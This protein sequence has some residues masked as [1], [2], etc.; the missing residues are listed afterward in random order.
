MRDAVLRALADLPD[1]PRPGGLVDADRAA[2]HRFVDRLRL[3]LRLGRLA[4]RALGPG[5]DWVESAR[6]GLRDRVFGLGAGAAAPDGATVAFR[7]A[8]MAALDPVLR[9]CLEGEGYA[10]EAERFFSELDVRLAAVPGFLRAL[11]GGNGRDWPYLAWVKVPPGAPAD[12][13]KR[14]LSRLFEAM[15][16]DVDLEAEEAVADLAR[17]DLEARWP[18]ASVWGIAPAEWFARQSWNRNAGVRIWWRLLAGELPRPGEDWALKAIADRAV[19][20]L[21]RPAPAGPSDPWGFARWAAEVVTAAERR[22]SEFLDAAGRK[23]PW[24]ATLSVGRNGAEP[25]VFEPLPAEADHRLVD[26]RLRLALVLALLDRYRRETAGSAEERDEHLIQLARVATLL[27][28]HP[29]NSRLETAALV[30]CH[31]ARRAVY[32]A[33]DEARRAGPPVDRHLALVRAMMRLHVAGRSGPPVEPP[34][35]RVVEEIRATSLPDDSVRFRLSDILEEMGG[36]W[37]AIGQAPAGDLARARADADRWLDALMPPDW[38]QAD[39]ILIN[40]TFLERLD[41]LTA[42]RLASLL[43]LEVALARLLAHHQKAAVLDPAGAA[44][45]LERIVRAYRLVDYTIW[46]SRPSF[47]PSVYFRE[48]PASPQGHWYPALVVLAWGGPDL[49][50]PALAL[51]DRL[52]PQDRALA[53]E[54]RRA[55]FQRNETAMVTLASILE[56]PDAAGLLSFRHFHETRTLNLRL[57]A[58]TRRPHELSAEALVR[59]A[60]D[61][62]GVNLMV[63]GAGAGLS[64]EAVWSRLFGARPG[65]ET[66]PE[67]LKR[68]GS[69]PLLLKLNNID[70]AVLLAARCVSERRLP[71]PLRMGADRFLVEGNRRLLQCAETPESVLTIAQEIADRAGRQRIERY[72]KFYDDALTRSGSDGQPVLSGGFREAVAAPFYRRNIQRQREF[73]TTAIDAWREATRG[74]AGARDGADQLRLGRALRHDLGPLAVALARGKEGHQPGQPY[75]WQPV[76]MLDHEDD[77]REARPDAFFELVAWWRTLARGDDPESIRG[78]LRAAGSADDDA[79]AGIYRRRCEREAAAQTRRLESLDRELRGAVP[80]S[81]DRSAWEAVELAW[82]RGPT[83]RE[84]L[85]RLLACSRKYNRWAETAGPSIGLAVPE[86]AGRKKWEALRP[87]WL[88]VADDRSESGWEIPANDGAEWRRKGAAPAYEF[89]L[90]LRWL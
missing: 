83:V 90:V 71:E 11:R 22:H 36:L 31:E 73:V 89:L 6:H 79:L 20:E 87:L 40:R 21:G 37:E 26:G 62:V 49:Q 52:E 38:R 51:L 9:S 32:A 14:R 8:L 18:G 78:M 66:P 86:A 55:I 80:D 30:K 29:D 61:G 25:F 5:H 10:E 43:K 59:G 50:R 69:R 44:A 4:G 74:R 75:L 67:S 13:A 35:Q 28:N 82:S 7:A 19:S 48:L 24:R 84:E 47:E 39:E 68:F 72:R 42:D 54:L 46:Y 58:E 56:K 53:S 33:L 60:F 81:P 65:V 70:A 88:P 63:A 1:R 64:D 12:V 27:P 85:A 17:A 34:F 77:V 76:D 57:L 15:A 45:D 41:A 16:V 2:I 23:L 3:A